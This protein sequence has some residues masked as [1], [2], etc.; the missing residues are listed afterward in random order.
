MIWNLSLTGMSYAVPLNSRVPLASII[1]FKLSSLSIP[2]NRDFILSRTHCISHFC[3]CR[4]A[5]RSLNSCPPTVFEHTLP[6]PWMKHIAVNET[7]RD[8]TT[9]LFESYVNV[10]TDHAIMAQSS[11]KSWNKIFFH[12]RELLVLK[13]FFFLTSVCCCLQ[14]FILHNVSTFYCLLLNMYNFIVFL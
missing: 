7:L 5:F 8:Y 12:G 10:I 11:R 4:I 6:F 2:S 3:Y 9:I 1:T 14:V 13:G